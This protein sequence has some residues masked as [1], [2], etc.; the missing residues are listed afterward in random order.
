MNT[1]TFFAGIFA[2]ML[3]TAPAFA[4]P[5][6]VESMLGDTTHAV[7]VLQ[8]EAEL[9]G[10]RHELERDRD[11]QGWQLTGAAGYGIIKNIVSANQSISYPGAQGQLGLSYPLLDSSGQKQR[12]A[13]SASGKVEEKQV[14]LDDARRR[15]PLELESDYARYWGAQEGMVVIDA[16]LATEPEVV[17]RLQLRQQKKLMLKSRLTE[18]LTGYEV[19]HA[20]RAQLQ[21]VLDQTRGRLERLIG[22]PLANFQASAVSLPEI[23]GVVA[24]DI[25][26]KYPN[27]AE[28]RAKADALQ[29]QL[30][31]SNW[32]GMNASLNVMGAVNTDQRDHQTGGTGF[33]GLNFSAPLSLLSVRRE[34]RERLQ[35]ELEGVRLQQRQRNEEVMAEAHGALNRLAEATEDMR[36]TAQKTSAVAE[37]LRERQLRSNVFSEEGIEALSQKLNDYALQALADIDA[38]VHVWQNNIDVRAYI[39]S[40]DNNNIV[41][42]SQDATVG[43]NLAEPLKTVAG[44]LRGS[45]GDQVPST[46]AQAPAPAAESG[47]LNDSRAIAPARFVGLTLKQSPALHSVAW[48]RSAPADGN[49]RFATNGLDAAAPPRLLMA[50]VLDANAEELKGTMTPDMSVYVWDSHELIRHS[51]VQPSFWSL[52][53]RLTINHLMVSL[54]A[55][56]IQAAQA[57]PEELQAFLSN[58]RAHGV[59]VDLLLG[60]PSWIEPEHRQELLNIIGSLSAFNFSGLHL[61]IEPDQIYR[62]PLSRTQF[63]DWVATLTDA[64]KASPWPTEV[65]VHPRYFR[66]S[67]YHDWHLGEQLSKDGIHKVALMIFSSDP[68]K[69]AAIARPILAGS[70]NLRFQIAQSVEPQ[71]GPKLSYARRSPEDFQAAMH[72]LDKQMSTE[73]NADGVVVQAWSDLTRMGHESQI[74]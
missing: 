9:D 48:V 72:D 13:D 58:A 26:D 37:A 25:S 1:K 20:D 56:Q 29:A 5:V 44:M 74:R 49:L 62:Q 7:A 40:A 6:P 52:L 63:D 32:Y 64:A 4:E 15:A 27:V 47:R 31:D 60:E 10:A 67:P 2:T 46:P 59:A 16:Y 73:A 70:P 43:A 42:H 19:A 3:A 17:P 28:L 36:V 14:R 71:L 33:V 51:Q 8:A 11:Q 66:D 24:D 35:S 53:K 55:T 65:S 57:R 68:N 22:H 21:R 50:Q 18:L 23:Q 41:P 38:R 30:D 69:V 61:D 54:N 12:A 39:M 34:E 45:G